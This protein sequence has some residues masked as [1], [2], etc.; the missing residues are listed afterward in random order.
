MY[1]FMSAAKKGDPDFSLTLQELYIFLYKHVIRKY[2][3]TITGGKAKLFHVILGK[4]RDR[5]LVWVYY[6]L[7]SLSTQKFCS[8]NHQTEYILN[9]LCR[10]LDLS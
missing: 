2:T 4:G 1:F 3:Y 8:L 9:S 5:N 7:F 6:C 10:V